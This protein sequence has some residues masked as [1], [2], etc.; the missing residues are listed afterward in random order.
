MRREGE[1]GGEGKSVGG[2]QG[3]EGGSEAAP[4]GE[5]GEGGGGGEGAEDEA[6]GQ[7]G[8]KVAGGQQSAV[9]Q[10]IDPSQAA[11]RAPRAAAAGAAGG[12]G[13]RTWGGGI[14]ANTTPYWRFVQ[15]ISAVGAGV[16]FVPALV[17]TVIIF[18]RS[19]C[20]QLWYRFCYTGAVRRRNRRVV[21]PS[22]L[23]VLP[24]MRGTLDLGERLEV[25]SWEGGRVVTWRKGEEAARGSGAGGAAVAGGGAGGGD[26]GSS[27]SEPAKEGEVSKGATGDGGG[28]VRIDVEASG[29]GASV[30]A[31]AESEGG[32]DNT[33]EGMVI[34]PASPMARVAENSY[35]RGIPRRLSLS[36][37]HAWTFT[38]T[39]VVNRT[40]VINEDTLL[41]LVRRRPKG[42]PL[43]TVSNHMST[44]DD[45]LL[46]NQW[47]LRFSD[48]YRCRWT[49]TARDICFTNPFTAYLF[50]LA[51]CI[52]IDRY[53]GIYQDGMTEAVQRLSAGGWLHI[54]PEGRITQE[55]VALARL[56]WGLAS[57]IDRCTSP[58]PPVI[59][60]VAHSGF[61]NVMPEPRAFGH[62]AIAPLWGQR[63]AVVVGEPFQFHMGALRAAASHAAAHPDESAFGADST[64]PASVPPAA[65]AAAAPSGASAGADTAGAAPA[66]PAGSADAVPPTSAA[67]SS[68]AT[69]IEVPG[70]SVTG[71]S[72]AVK[73]EAT[74]RLYAFITGEVRQRL[75]VA[76]DEAHRRQADGCCR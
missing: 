14:R 61:E 22:C 41:E 57:V 24:C 58:V 34:R 76:V 9:S 31:G 8:G 43:I 4:G 68:G 50:R 25:V 1:E 39:H 32:G 23:S 70:S 3:G 27:S 72:S 6:P 65:A 26:A 28:E 63:I 69:A 20:L 66:A 29:G 44:L 15:I 64:P 36:F 19:L 60:C 73:D 51:K 10:Q 2:M 40:K 21:T 18:L 42:T 45:P 38:Y 33:V 30:E 56:K 55:H 5:G 62:R 49:L 35:Q 67:T 17:F 11:S 71:G 54:F 12:G 46:W 47:R 74:R 16:I 59:L 48:P 13:G 7:S 37:V 75:Q 52:P 53:G